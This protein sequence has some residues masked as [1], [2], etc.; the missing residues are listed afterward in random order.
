[1][2]AQVRDM[3]RHSL[4][5]FLARDAEAAR[6]VASR[7]DEIDHLYKSVFDDLLKIMLDDPSAATRATYLLWTA[8][9]LERMGDRVTNIA[10]RV[11]YM[12]T[13]DMTELN[14]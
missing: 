14:V 13:G 10:E 3:L 4:D 8:H 2:A 9:N 12:T 5:A 6:V 1:M 11:I 7:D